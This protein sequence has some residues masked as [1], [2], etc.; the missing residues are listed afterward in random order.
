MQNN[1]GKRWWNTD[2]IELLVLILFTAL[3]IF[4]INSI[5]L[6]GDNSKPK[7]YAHIGGITIGMD[8][9]QAI[10][11]IK[12][13]LSSITFN[14]TVKTEL[15]SQGDSTGYTYRKFNEKYYITLDSGK[16]ARVFFHSDSLTDKEV[17]VIEKSN[18]LSRHKLIIHKGETWT[19]FQDGNGTYIIYKNE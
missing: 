11:L 7:E 6:L 4:T 9:I 3:L 1:T 13:R 10:N 2:V 12:D 16:V 17:K 14:Q 18:R 5:Y 15:Q 19:S 8:S